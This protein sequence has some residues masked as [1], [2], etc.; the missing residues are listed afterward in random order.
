MYDGNLCKLL[1][2]SYPI[3]YVE[4]VF[5]HHACDH[6]HSMYA[7]C[8]R[9]L[10]LYVGSEG[11]DL[12]RRDEDEEPLDGEFVSKTLHVTQVALGHDAKEGDHTVYI[13]REGSSYALGTLNKK[14][15]PH[16]KLDLVLVDEEVVMKHTGKSVVHVT[17][18]EGLSYGAQDSEDDDDD[19]YED[20]LLE[21]GDTDSDDGEEDSEDE[22]SEDEEVPELVGMQN[23]PS[24]DDDDSVDVADV[25]DSDIDMGIESDDSDD[26]DS[27]DDDSDDDDDLDGNVD[28]DDSSEEFDSDA[29]IDMSDSD[30]EDEREGMK[31]RLKN[32]LMT[33]QPSKKKQK[34]ADAP[35]TAPSKIAVVKTPTNEKEYKNALKI[36]LKDN[37]PSKLASLGS[38]VKRPPSVPKLKKFL[39]SNTDAFGYNTSTDMVSLL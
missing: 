23:I 38:A 31:K 8:Q 29:E 11:I 36:F 21:G 10:N 19:G 22:D 26:D 13:E 15:C 27:D 1:C 20:L 3:W 9:V 5:G 14:T 18:Y 34:V 37:G 32:V 12:C 6:R 33:P 4:T 30:D 25:S 7:N 2:C 16:M 28:G 24:A 35:A 39:A 17:G